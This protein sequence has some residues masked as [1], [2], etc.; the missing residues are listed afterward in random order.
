MYDLRLIPSVYSA[1]TTSSPCPYTDKKSTRYTH[2]HSCHGNYTNVFY[3]ASK[4]LVIDT[5]S[6]KGE[7]SRDTQR[8][9]CFIGEKNTLVH[10]FVVCWFV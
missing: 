7:D 3:C 9:Q 4:H 8:R 5:T 1:N 2:T 6:L 10:Q